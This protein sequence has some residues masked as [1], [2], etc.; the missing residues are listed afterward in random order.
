[1]IVSPSKVRA[2]ALAT[3][4]ACRPAAQFARVGQDFIDAIEAATRAA[5]VHRVKSHPS[6]GVTLK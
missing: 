2:L 5:I 3:A 6:K 1:M 4:Q